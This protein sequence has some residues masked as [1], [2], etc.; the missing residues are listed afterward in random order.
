MPRLLPSSYAQPLMLNG[1]GCVVL[2]SGDEM[3]VL[4]VA[5]AALKMRSGPVEC[6]A[7]MSLS[8]PL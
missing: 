6:A 3:I 7:L 8:S 2:G 4:G 5:A 1:V